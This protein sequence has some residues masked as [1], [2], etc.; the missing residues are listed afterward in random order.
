[1]EDGHYNNTH[2]T[3]GK[4]RAHMNTIF[5]R[6]HDYIMF[7]TSYKHVITME[8]GHDN[9]THSTHGQLHA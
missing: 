4:L 7:I 8:Y 3:H 1:M 2:S 6:R 9:S 5:V